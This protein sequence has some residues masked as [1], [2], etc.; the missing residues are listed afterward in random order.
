MLQIVRAID[1]GKRPII[2]EDCDENYKKII[3]D[4]WNEDPEE[5]P[6]FSSIYD[7]LESI[8][9]VEINKEE[10]LMMEKEKEREVDVTVKNW[11]LGDEN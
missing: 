9:E 11:F 4:C 7:S 6:T 10:R 5:R 3:E 1:L 2:P 8:Y